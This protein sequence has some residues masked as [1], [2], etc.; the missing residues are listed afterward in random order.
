MKKLALV[1]V[2][3][4]LLL[5]MPQASAANTVI[6][7]TGPI[8]QT[9]TGEFRNDDLAQSLTPSGDLGLKVFQ[10]IAKNRTWVI[11]AALIDEVIL[12]SG[13]YTLATEAEPAGKEIAT[14]WLTQLKRVTTGNDVVALAYGNPDISLAKRLAPSELKNYFAYGQDRLQLALGRIVR[15]EPEVQWSVGKS[16]LSNPLRKSYSD[17]RKA[18]TRLSRVVDTPEL[19]QLRAR[20]AQL[21]S[22][23]LDKDSRN[24]FSYSATEAVNAMV[25]KL[26]INSGKYQIT[27]SSV[28]LPVTV[29]NEFAVDVTVDIAMLPINSRVVVDS[30]DD[31]VIPANS[32]RQLEMQVDVIAPGQT[33]VSALITD[34]D[35][36][37]EVVPEAL[38][39]LNSTVIDSKVTWFTTGAA[40]LLLLAA[41]AQSVR[42]VRR[43]GK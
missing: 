29:I 32:K 22:P 28:K 20:L 2:S 25:N 36:D 23:T 39:T 1:V 40:I 37:T 8:H 26:R 34:S 11:D 41:V 10:P 35:D 42:R 19:I 24:Y 6:R 27:T 30:F 12:M 3:A 31:V 14:A 16:G 7:I 38:L 21:L 15:S 18:L 5:M 43:R 4:F 33:T 17:N 13:E 9:F